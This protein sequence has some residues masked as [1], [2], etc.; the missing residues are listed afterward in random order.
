MVVTKPGLAKRGIAR[1]GAD[2]HR[3]GALGQAHQ[4]FERFG[5]V[6]S[7]QPVITVPALATDVQQARF[8]Q[9]RE[10]AAR[11]RR[12]NSARFGELPRGEGAPVH[13]RGQH[14]GARR[15][16]DQGGDRSD[17]RSIGHSSVI[18]EA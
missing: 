12:R 16:A 4:R 17:E 8:D 11:R 5:H 15:I 9:P 14:V 10:M 13:Q 2:R 6:R 1:A 7:G 3:A 18:T